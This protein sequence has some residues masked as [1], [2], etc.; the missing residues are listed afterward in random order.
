MKKVCAWLLAFVMVAGMTMPVEAK[1]PGEGYNPTEYTAPQQ[2]T[3][4][5]TNPEDE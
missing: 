5:L 4:L 3:D 2:E 1:E